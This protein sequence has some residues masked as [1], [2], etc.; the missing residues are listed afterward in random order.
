M[1]KKEI[2]SGEHVE[3]WA[4]SL[5]NYSFEENN[6]ITTVTIETDS[7]ENYVDYLL[8]FGQKH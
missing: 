4:R 7:P 3:S 5:E 8:A 2:T 1:E 6:G